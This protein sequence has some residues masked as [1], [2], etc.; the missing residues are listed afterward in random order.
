M[1]YFI[2]WKMHASSRQ[3][4][5]AWGNASNPILY[6]EPGILVLFSFP[7]YGCLF[8]SYDILHHMINT[9]V[10]PSKSHSVGRCSKLTHWRELRKLVPIHFPKYGWFSSIKFRSY[11]LQHHKG[12]AWVF[13]SISHIIRKGNKTHPI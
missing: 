1:I 10:L 9:W 11:G 12:N 8:L 3:H 5:I 7:K 6:K 4:S 13:P 2:T